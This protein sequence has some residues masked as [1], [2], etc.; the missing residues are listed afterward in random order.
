[1]LRAALTGVVIGVTARVLMR[2]AVL[3]SGSERGFNPGA[4]TMIIALFVV[5][6]VGSWLGAQLFAR[7]PFAGVVVTVLALV[8]LWLPGGSIAVVE[9]SSRVR[10]AADRDLRGGACRADD[11][12]L[13]VVS[14]PTSGLAGRA[15]TPYPARQEP[16]MSALLCSR[17]RAHDRTIGILQRHSDRADRRSGRFPYKEPQPGRRRSGAGTCTGSRPAFPDRPVRKPSRDPGAIRNLSKTRPS[18]GLA[19]AENEWSQRRPAVGR[20]TR[21]PA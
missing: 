7:W 15:P 3:V 1:M 10:W 11:R 14:C 13:H 6:A 4:T 16:N 18:S 21:L 12:W 19:R 17:V 5:A 2:V 20:R 8:P 9:V